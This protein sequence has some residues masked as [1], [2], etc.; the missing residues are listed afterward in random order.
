MDSKMIEKTWTLG[1][2]MNV[3][4]KHAYMS[5]LSFLTYIHFIVKIYKDTD[6]SEQTEEDG[7]Q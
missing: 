5:S 2:I 4:R 7:Q 1:M 3:S 6:M